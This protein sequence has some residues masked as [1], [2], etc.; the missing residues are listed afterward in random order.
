MQLTEAIIEMVKGGIGIGVLA[1][2]AVAPQLRDGS[3]VAVSLTRRGIHR[4]WN[5]V[6]LKSRSTPPFIEKFVSLLRNGPL[7]SQ[8]V[9][10]RIRRQQAS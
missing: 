7:V 1:R 9:P 3:L 10:S 6:T 2:W 4:S 8:P 5:A